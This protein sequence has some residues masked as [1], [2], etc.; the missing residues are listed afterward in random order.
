[1]TSR[2][3]TTPKQSLPRFH[4]PDL[5]V[6]LNAPQLNAIIA[7][8]VSKAFTPFLMKMVRKFFIWAFILDLSKKGARREFMAGLYTAPSVYHARDL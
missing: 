6:K 7:E 2:E 5:D 3:A 1:M 4:H 8:L